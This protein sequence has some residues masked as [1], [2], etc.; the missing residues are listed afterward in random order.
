MKNLLKILRSPV[1]VAALLGT[2][3]GGIGGAFVPGEGHVCEPDAVLMERVDE[4]EKMH[5][6]EEE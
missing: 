6:V 4:L 2:A 3:G 1:M 5:P